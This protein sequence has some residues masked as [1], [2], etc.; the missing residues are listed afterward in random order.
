MRMSQQPVRVAIIG[1]GPGGLMSAYFLE[2]RTTIPCAITL[3]EASGRL[4]GKII[5]RQFKKAPV[6]YEAGAAEF[7]DYSQVGQDPLRE[8]IDELGLST[9]P[10]RGETIVLGDRFIRR[11]SDL[12]KV[13]GESTWRALKQFKNRARSIISPDDYYDFGYAHG[14]GHAWLHDDFA[15]AL[16]QITDETARKYIEVCVHSDVATEPTCTSALYGLQNYLMNEPDYMSL[17]TID[18]GLERLPQELA[19]RISAKIQLNHRVVRVQKAE[20]HRYRVTSRH[21]GKEQFEDFDFVIVALPNNWIPHIEWSGELLT[22]AMRKH[23]ATYKHPAHYMRVTV[24][25]K[26][27]FWREQI[28]ESYFMIDAFGGCCLYDES[29][30][31][32]S[33]YGVLGWLLAGESA[34]TMGNMDDQSLLEAILDSLPPSL[35]HGRDLFIEHQVHRWLGSVSGLPG[36]T[37]TDDA[38]AHHQP[39]PKRHPELFVV[40]DYLFDSTVNGVLDS[41]DL[42]SDWITE[43]IVEREVRGI[44]SQPQDIIVASSNGKNGTNGNGKHGKVPDFYLKKCENKGFGLFTRKA[45][46]TSDVVL[47]M[48]GRLVREAKDYALQVT[49]DLF[50]DWH[51]ASKDDFINHS[52]DPNCQLIVD[53]ETIHSTET[54]LVVALRDIGPNEEITFNYNTTEYDIDHMS[55]DCQCGSPDCVGRVRGFKYLAKPQRLA[56]KP[57]LIPYLYEKL[58]N[59][60]GRP[61]KKKSSSKQL[62][63]QIKRRRA[64]TT[65]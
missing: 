19:R 27:P 57:L 8:L 35:Q 40:G 7:Y 1:G 42:V 18:G 62:P 2:R 37:P 30:R 32:G 14:N 26:K 44:I 16:A 45:F 60:N 13:F 65:D 10:M 3:F 56:L 58:S 41:A 55:F 39:E 36:C 17:Y 53:A 50:L 6:T 20:N 12:K 38:E 33:G 52:C 61:M 21:R 51:R 54:V 9:S 29:S 25:F 15:Q 4:G 64:M 46:K 22:E 34:M 28:A 24:L 31:N 48:T 43:C 59:G 47:E 5:T 11:D 23:H 63:A 49:S